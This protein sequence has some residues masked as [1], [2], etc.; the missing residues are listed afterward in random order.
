MNP[1][2]PTE[3]LVIL[4]AGLLAAAA[5]TSWRSSALCSPRLRA[6]L[7]VLRV[8]AVACAGVIAFNPG[9][10]RE[11]ETKKAAEWA[12]LVDSSASMGVAD[13]KGAARWKE[14]CRLSEK[15]AAV[16]DAAPVKFYSFAGNLD[17]VESAA[18]LSSRACD[19]DTTDILRAGGGLLDIYQPSGRR[20]MGV[21]VLSDGHQIRAG[22]PDELVSRA[23]S[24]Q[25]PVYA[26]PL[27]GRVEAKDLGLAPERRHYIAFKGRPLRVGIKLDARG[28]ENIRPVVQ[29]FDAAGKKVGEK[30]VEVARAGTQVGEFEIAPGE[31]GT[32]EYTA[33]VAPWEGETI[34]VNN[35]CRVSVSV[36]DEK[37]R[38]L[39]VEGTPNWDSKFIAQLLQKQNNVTLTT[40]YRIASD[41]FLSIE[42]GGSAAGE[43]PESAFPQDAAAFQK[44]DLV[45]FG[46]GAEYFLTPERA[47][48]LKTF[49]GDHGG[50]VL[51]A[52][53]KPYA[54]LLPEL[55]PLEPVTWGGE[56]VADFRWHPTI[57]GEDA[58]LFG[59]LLPGVKDP[60]WEKL[61]PLSHAQECA[62]L[63]VFAQV[64]AEGV[65][66]GGG[67]DRSFPVVL[68]HRFGK[69]LVITVNL[70]GLWQ[71]DFFPTQENS[72]RIYRDFW[73]QIL[74]WS[75]TY[76]DF[77]P[78]QE[79]ALRLGESLVDVEQPVSARVLKRTPLKSGKAPVLRI[80]DGGQLA[81]EV[82]L[83][84]S[85]SAPEQW[86]GVF[87]LSK[88]GS[89][90]VELATEGTNATARL[91]EPLQVRMPPA[92][93]DDTSCD[94][95]FLARLA[96]KTGGRIIGEAD[97]E[98][99]LRPGGPPKSAAQ[100]ENTEWQ[101]AW[102]RGGVLAALAALFAA[103]WFLRRRQGL[104]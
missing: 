79:Y 10:W 104:I 103:E 51:F 71:W 41:R 84:A 8:A 40:I 75:V 35:Q 18:K 56:V 2:L 24:L 43:N 61:P 85:A 90:L 7:L 60:V 33:K 88:P 92:E 54:G 39:F 99:L 86:E 45:I 96:E 3:Y 46:R 11:D 25:A 57:A 38:V 16:R 73:N 66:A 58:G 5:V 1:I 19:G 50:G 67:R 100:K 80:F 37:I 83:P 12:V 59:E 20:L 77:L 53:G 34:V 78:G 27:G 82:A 44:F 74:L 31:H 101:P 81:Q 97:I 22:S 26:M 9:R 98:A 72:G 65:I 68:S 93:K 28:L 6:T 102:S 29:L 17:P 30:T 89:Y 23:R 69:G 32:S 36:M 94:E 21:I 15:I 55:E 87:S 49:V 4:L 70:D 48:H 91:V 14:A 63:K 76:S 62:R 64:L 13:V 42:G 47:R 52:R 95:T